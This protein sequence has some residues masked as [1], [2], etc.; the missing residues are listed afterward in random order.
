LLA[1]GLADRGIVA[2][3]YTALPPLKA[4]TFRK[5]R[6]ARISNDLRRRKLR[7]SR[8]DQVET[9]T[10]LAVAAQIVGQTGLCIAPWEGGSSIARATLRW[11]PGRSSVRG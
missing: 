7:V 11:S 3:D 6:P 10:G 5:G 2:A 1:E 9:Y 8:G 4:S